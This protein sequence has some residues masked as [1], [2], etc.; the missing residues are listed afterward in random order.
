VFYADIQ[1][2]GSVA[3][4]TLQVLR[5]GSPAVAVDDRDNLDL[6]VTASDGDAESVMLRARIQQVAPMEPST[7][8]WGLPRAIETEW[9]QET[10]P[11]RIR[12]GE[13]GELHIADQNHKVWDVSLHP[14]RMVGNVSFGPGCARR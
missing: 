12:Y 11:I 6:Q 8:Q 9:S 4:T 1:S 10:L 5:F 7:F 2:V 13:S 3:S 14:D